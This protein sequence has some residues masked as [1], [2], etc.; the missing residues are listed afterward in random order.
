MH[1]LHLP[2]ADPCHENW[3]AMGDEG[4]GKRFCESCSKKVHDL[5][6]LTEAQARTLLEAPRPASGLCIRYAS[7]H[8]GTVRFR[9]PSTQAPAPCVFA[10]WRAGVAAG[11][12]ALAMTGCADTERTPTRVTDTHCSYK[13]GPF[14]YTLARGEGNCPAA[15]GRGVFV[16][17]PAPEQVMGQMV[18]VA[19]DPG[20]EMGEMMPEPPRLDSE[21]FLFELLRK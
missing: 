8:D 16:T 13:V 18:Q 4:G 19:S 15:E 17:D 14:G 21:G 2:I 12:A 7:H 1:K 11:V 9:T 20:P 5:S 3:E 6:Q 10:G